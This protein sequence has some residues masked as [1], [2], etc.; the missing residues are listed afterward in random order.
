MK[1]KHE[2]NGFPRAFNLQLHVK[3]LSEET[4]MRR[5]ILISVL[6]VA[7]C[8]AVR[9][10]KRP[11]RQRSRPSQATETTAPMAVV[12]PALMRGMKFRLLGPSRGGRVTAVT[13][14]PSQ[15]KTFY[16]GVASG[17]LFRTT[18]SGVTWTPIADE[19][20]IPV[21][22]M[23]AIAVPTAIRTS[24]TSEP[25]RTACAATCRPAAAST[26][27]RTAAHVEV[28]RPL[29]QRT[30]RGRPHPSDQS[31]HRLDL[32]DGR[33]LQGQRRARHLQDDRRRRHVEESAVPVGHLGAM[34]VE[35]QPG[36]PNVVY[37]WMSR[38]ERKPWT[39]ISGSREGGFYKSTN[40]GDTFTKTGTGLPAELI[41][42]ANMAVTAANPNRIYALI[43][44]A[45]GGGMYRSDDA[46]RRGRRCRRRRR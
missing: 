16:M 29:Q 35:L 30:D 13:G 18:D 9:R 44:A 17:G 11:S 38:L 28:R 39:I 21:G 1:M 40:G 19:G 24:S 7:A 37:A 43:E 23:G 14:V 34:D 3:A 22:S 33:H 8:A 41:G 45:P 46:G 32:G 5:S 25:A 6:G 10:R 20:K 4:T 15:P 42:K 36:N 26:R 31:Q 2:V 27:R 12:D